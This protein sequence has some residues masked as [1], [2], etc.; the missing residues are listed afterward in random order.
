MDNLLSDCHVIRA[1]HRHQTKKLLYLASSCTYPRRC[2]QPMAPR[3]LMAGPLEPSS[4]AYAIAKISGMKLC[5]AYRRQHGANFIV[6]IPANAFGIG[7]DFSLESS[8]V[9]P[10]LIRK[11]DAI[12][13]ADSTI[14]TNEAT[15]ALLDKAAR[16][17]TLYRARYPEKLK[18]V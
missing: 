16:V 2:P 8:H 14:Q 9:I 15:A 6:G 11:M 4:E 17:I 3:S 12:A 13:N 10:A 7:D 5:Q 1:A 18:A